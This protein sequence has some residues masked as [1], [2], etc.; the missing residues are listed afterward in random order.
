MRLRAVLAQAA[1]EALAV[2]SGNRRA[3]LVFLSGAQGGQASHVNG[4]WR[5]TAE[6]QGRRVV[7]VKVGDDSTCIEHFG[8]QWQLKLV[9][10][11]GQNLCIAKVLG[12]C[13]FEDCTLHVWSVWDGKTQVRQPSVKML[14]GADAER[15]KAAGG[16]GAA[17]S[18][19]SH[20][21]CD[22]YTLF[23]AAYDAAQAPQYPDQLLAAVRKTTFAFSRKMR[24]G[25]AEID[26]Y[27]RE[28]QAEALEHKDELQDSMA[29]SAVLIW[30]SAKRLTLQPGS[31]IEFCSLLNRILREHDPDLLP[32]ACEV[33]RGINLLCVTRHDETKLLYPPGGESHR[34]GGLPLHHVPF[35]VVDKKF[36]V[37]M[38]LATSFDEEVAY[39][40]CLR[41]RVCVVA[42][43]HALA[44]GSG[45]WPS[46]LVSRPCTG[47]CA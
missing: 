45:S 10:H 38:F 21:G 19:L 27:F 7:Y 11:K 34:G 13:T 17:V 28:V 6:R 2:E 39:K 30:T 40:C 1:A 26:R 15:E 41:A 5:A 25:E 16:G 23:L 37:P 9:S 12:G 31:T 20:S 42:L 33:V 22:A 35:F 18:S 3:G 14:C 24:V 32:S 8:G 46:T 47:S 36:R 43:C 44:S 29:E 4:F